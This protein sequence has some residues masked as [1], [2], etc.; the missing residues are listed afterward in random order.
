MSVTRLPALGTLVLL[1]GCLSQPRDEDLGLVL[2]NLVM[3]CSI[4]PLLFSEG[5]LRRSGSGG[6]GK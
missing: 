5:K 4:T 1:L 3:P 6:D 2:L